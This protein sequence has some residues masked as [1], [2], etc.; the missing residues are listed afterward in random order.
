MARLPALVEVLGRHHPRGVVGVENYARI[1]RKAKKITPSKRGVGAANVTVQDA[2]NLIFGLA[3]MNNA[4][5]APVAVDLFRGAMLVGEM[6]GEADPL[7]ALDDYEMDL[8]FDTLGDLLDS[9][10]VQLEANP[11]PRK[12][13][14]PGY[15]R[16]IDIRMQNPNILGASAYVRFG[17]EA[18]KYVTLEYF[19][20]HPEF[21]IDISDGDNF[22]K[23][24]LDQMEVAD[25]HPQA[26][27]AI[28]FD[29]NIS[30]VVLTSVARCV[31]REDGK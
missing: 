24:Y 12:R 16:S 14:G 11:L 22:V 7:D 6:P 18:R 9:I 17:T 8:R 10:L 29:V 1:L 26:S 21:E 15:L 19:F 5:F 3:E 4:T 27:F 31:L 23:N 30:F 13:S 25:A 2:S 20:T 28:S